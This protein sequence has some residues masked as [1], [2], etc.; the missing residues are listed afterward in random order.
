MGGND[1]LL[2]SVRRRHDPGAQWRVSA[3]RGNGGVGFGALALER[4]E[5][6]VQAV[7]A[8]VQDDNAAVA[9]FDLLAQVVTV[10]A[11]EGFGGGGQGAVLFSLS[12]PMT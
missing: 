10:R 9:R 11:G 7:D 12:G 6:R 5:Q 8:G 2:L 4:D 1:V 3:Q